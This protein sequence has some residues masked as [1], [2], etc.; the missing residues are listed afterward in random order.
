MSFPAI[1]AQDPPPVL[2]PDDKALLIPLDR[3][4][5]KTNT[6]AVS[7]NVSFLRRTEYISVRHKTKFHESPAR[8]ELEEE[9][10]TKERDDDPV[11]M[12]QSILTGFDIVAGTVNQADIKD[13]HMQK[14]A[15]EWEK[16]KPGYKD[17]RTGKTVVD[18]MP[19]FPDP[20]A[21]ADGGFMSV[22]FNV[23]PVP[24]RDGGRRDNRLD[25][26]LFR[27]NES[28]N[29]TFDYYL[30]QSNELIPK[31]H[32]AFSVPPPDNLDIGT[33]ENPINYTRLREYEQAQS[34]MTGGVGTE[35]EIAEYVLVF[36]DEDTEER[37][38]GAYWVPLM[39]KIVLRPKRNER[40]MKSLFRQTASHHVNEE[41]DKVDLIKLSVREPTDEERLRR[42]ENVGDADADADGEE[43]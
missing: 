2:H 42:G 28:A 34:V 18:T 37:P 31:I 16:I 13:S 15:A 4:G 1:L 29:P 23:P 24:P 6:A 35:P 30:P 9:E 25:L 26:G 21:S 22:K 40:V 14:A 41:E 7:T 12:L 10:E 36:Q 20:L 19:I 3:I 38:K 8:R 17:P 33:P 43:E 27:V 5:K 32:D 11:R 39:T